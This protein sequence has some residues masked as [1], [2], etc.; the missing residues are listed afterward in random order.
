[1][2]EALLA[3]ALWILATLGLFYGSTWLFR[4]TRFLLFNPVLMTIAALIAILMLLGIDYETYDYGGRYIR[5]LLEPS[6]VALGVPLYLN[7]RAIAMRARSIL[8]A[9]GVGSI[10][11]VTT[12]V[13]IAAGMGASAEVAKTLA[14]RSVTTPIAIGI[15]ERI[16]GIA[17]LAAAVVVAS[18]VFGAVVGPPVLRRLGITSKTAFGLATGA[19]AHGIGTARAV[20]EGPLEG[21]AAGVAIGLMGIATAVVAPFLIELF[22]WIGAI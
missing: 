13:L 11:G 3:G 20:Q 14:P 6:V 12:A 9:I 10:V 22:V 21:A 17:P 18:G 1:M 15:A 7:R 5:L 16:G 19:S 2:T 8:T 4:R